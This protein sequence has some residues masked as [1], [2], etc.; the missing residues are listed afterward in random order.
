M[1][2]LLIAGN[3]KMNH[4]PSQSREFGRNLKA[5]GLQNFFP[6]IL[7]CPPYVSIQPL[8]ESLEGTPVKI[9]GQ[10]LHQELKGAYTGEISGEMLKETGCVY[11]LIG[12]SE[13]R[14]Y[15]Y[16]TDELVHTK[17]LRAHDAGLV[18]IVCIGE[19]LEDREKGITTDVI[20]QQLKGALKELRP[21]IMKTLV[22]AYEPVWAIGTGKTATAGQAQEVHALIRKILKTSFSTEISENT[23]ILYGG[24]AKP[25]NAEELLSEADIDGLLIGGASLKTEDFY[26]IIGI[27]HQLMNKG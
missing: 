16:E 11:V 24:S 3:W 25:N 9:G 1:R 10:N 19:T 6:E 20:T 5:K 18:P 22:L 15:F 26:A 8:K 21:E 13:R 17:I 14:Q 27:A 2:R 4:G 7:L 12:H 23:R